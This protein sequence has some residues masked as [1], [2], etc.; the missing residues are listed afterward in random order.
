LIYV[1]L[2]QDGSYETWHEYKSLSSES[3]GLRYGLRWQPGEDCLAD[4]IS[5]VP[6]ASTH[7][8][9]N[10]ATR[11]HDDTISRHVVALQTKRTAWQE[12]TI[13]PLPAAPM[14]TF[15]LYVDPTF[16]V[17]I[18]MA[19]IETMGSVP[20]LMAL[21]MSPALVVTTLRIMKSMREI[22]YKPFMG[23]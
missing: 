3:E 15:A 12:Q 10:E 16:I 4:T 23:D 18:V 20:A 5:Y 11:L 7:K 13:A 17:Q 1:K 14:G 2:S 8:G 21:T 6:P 22:S 19:A 9:R